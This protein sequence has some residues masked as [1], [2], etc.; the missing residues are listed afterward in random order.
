M[1]FI[2][3]VKTCFVKYFDF[4]GR[5]SRSEFWYFT[6]FLV[7][8]VMIVSFFLGFYFGYNYPGWTQQ[9]FDKMYDSI[10]IFIILPLASPILAVTARRFHDFGHSGWIQIGFYFV[11][12]ISEEINTDA[13]VVL[14]LVS[15]VLFYVYASQKPIGDNKYGAVIQ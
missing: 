2:E 4:S 6:L 10:Y 9:Q 12:S 1:E 11:M 15:H 13:G 14:Y 8:Y 7:L 5:A 3:S